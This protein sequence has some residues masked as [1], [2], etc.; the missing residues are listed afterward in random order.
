MPLNAM[1]L[2]ATLAIAAALV[3]CG[4]ADT[5][6]PAHSNTPTW[7]ATQ[8]KVGPFA[9]QAADQAA[10][11]YVATPLPRFNDFKDAWFVTGAPG[12]VI[13]LRNDATEIV[14]F[15]AGEMRALP[16]PAHLSLRQGVVDMFMNLR[17]QILL[18]S[19][20]GVALWTSPEWKA[21]PTPTLGAGETV[22][23][24]R[25]VALNN[26][27]QVLLNLRIK[28]ADDMLRDRA[29]LISEGQ[30]KYLEGKATALSD[31]GHVAVQE[32]RQGNMQ[33]SVYLPSGEYLMGGRISWGATTYLPEVQSIKVDGT[34][35]GVVFIPNIGRTKWGDQATQSLLSQSLFRASP[36]SLEL[37]PRGAAFDATHYVDYFQGYR[38]FNRQGN[39]A[40]AVSL[41]PF[42]GS[43]SADRGLGLMVVNDQIF[44]ANTL[45]TPRVGN[46]TQT[47]VP[48][49]GFGDSGEIIQ[50][51]PSADNIPNFWLIQPS[52]AGLGTKL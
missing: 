17:G 9:T 1:R 20:E 28:G 47:I 10:I 49:W 44:D 35:M 50:M 38:P 24:T 34:A 37:W 39:F 29:M 36:E 25:A 48:I 4:G 13:G 3:A 5:T 22:V 7:S 31:A 40:A 21:L 15:E 42:A 45:L 26:V 33:A 52:P 41:A 11:S 14:I 43:T 12:Q 32:E 46:P 30:A 18:E 19:N 8:V 51:E 27:G 6:A 23:A 16:P 2:G